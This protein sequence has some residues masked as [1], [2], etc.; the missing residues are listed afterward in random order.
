MRAAHLLA[1]SAFGIAQ[2]AFDLLSKNP[3]FFV[4][5]GFHAV[6]VVLYGL[7]VLLVPPAIL[8]ALELAA[9]IV[10]PRLVSIVH[11]LFVGMLVFIFVGRGTQALPPFAKA[12]VGLVFACLYAS[13]RPVQSFVSVSA[14]AS[15][16]FLGLFLANAP[17]A[18]LSVT[19]APAAAIPEG[20]PR[21]P[22]VLVIFDEF[23]VSS[24]MT[25][26]SRIDASRYPSF[27][28]LAASATW[29]RNATAVHDHTSWAV[30][31]ILTG[32]RPRRDQLPLLA[33]HPQNL[34]TLLGGSYR[35]HGFESVTRL[36]P[37]RLCR[38]S[39]KPLDTRVRTLASYV[40]STA[41]Y[42]QLRTDDV[43]PWRDPPAQVAR[44]LAAVHPGGD[45]ELY[46]LHLLLPHAPWRYLPSGRS[47]RGFQAPQGVT[48]DVW[49]NDTRLVD[50]RYREHLLQVGY[51]DRVLGRIVRRLRA[52]GLWNR[53]L[54]VVAADHGCSFLP[55]DHERTVNLANIGDIAPVPLF[56]KTPWERA[57]RIDDRSART[58]DIVPTI[59]DVLGDT[60]PWKID[61]RSLL[62]AD[63]P[64]PSTV[65]IGRP[66]GRLVKAS[67]RLAEA[68][69]ARTIARRARIVKGLDRLR[70]A[71]AR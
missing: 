24:L 60:M 37:A 67:W 69:R 53:S 9:E 49:R 21:P 43:R 33:D 17:I 63:R 4:V 15:L 8:V 3:D 10:R 71:L 35:I 20:G 25:T 56:V 32:Q 29:Y 14:L 44:F 58:I 2:P 19:D 50:R 12:V 31:A 13:W 57:G 42:G 52:T 66:D 59:A 27:A 48:R 7:A 62:R 45:R 18:K 40:G 11:P 61:G 39:G 47:Y 65:V 46:V 70:A 41:F 6:D 5:E 30:P 38:N 23:P 54:L 34:F 64:Y 36:C 22:V 51:V 28:A 68:G 26:N 55:G 1:L 16:V